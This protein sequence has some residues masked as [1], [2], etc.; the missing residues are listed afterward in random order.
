MLNQASF[1][2]SSSYSTQC[3]KL[4]AGIKRPSFSYND[5][6]ALYEENKDSYNEIDNL[7]DAI[8]FLYRLGAIGNSWKAKK[9]KHRTCWYYKID[10]IDEVDLSKNFTIH[11]GLR[12]KFSL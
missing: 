9:G 1:Y 6:K 2:K 7:D 11:Y 5:I 12:K 4:I 3:L 8:H 10:T